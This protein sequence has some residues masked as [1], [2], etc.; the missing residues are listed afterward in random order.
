MKNAVLSLFLLAISFWSEAQ[1]IDSTV[2]FNLRGTVISSS[3]TA[4]VVMTDEAI[5]VYPNPSNGYFKISSE[6][7][8]ELQSILIVDQSG[9][10]IYE[11]NDFNRTEVQM[12]AKGKSGIYM[13]H[14]GSGGK[15]FSKRVFIRNNDPMDF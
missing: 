1:E 7:L 11:G 2:H 3:T 13:A 15:V 8:G 14:V 6:I 12:D 4:N 10:V 5:N 9:H